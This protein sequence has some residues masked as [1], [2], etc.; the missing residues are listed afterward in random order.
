[1]SLLCI[2]IFKNQHST[3]GIY[4]VSHRCHS[5]HSPLMNMCAGVKKSISSTVIASCIR[6]PI[7]VYFSYSLSPTIFKT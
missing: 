5:P 4:Q 7:S 1:M 2:W 3:L 6:L